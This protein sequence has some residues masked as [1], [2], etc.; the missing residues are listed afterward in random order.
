MADTNREI[1]PGKIR[2]DFPI[3]R[4]RIQGRP[5]AY[6]DNAATAQRPRQV[7]SAV[8]EFYEQRNANVHR[9][10]HTLS[11]EASL[12]YEEAHHKAA[13]FIGAAGPEEIVF[14]HN[15]T[16]A[17]N[18]VAYAFGLWGLRQGDEVLLT[19]AEHHSNLV[20]WQALRRLKGV[21]LKF[22]DVD[23][24]GRLKLEELPQLLSGR[25]KLVGIVHASNILGT[26]NPVAEISREAH[27]VGAR[28]LVD[29]AQS[30][31]HLPLDVAE[32]D[33]DFLAASGHKMLGPTGTGFLY[34]K[35]DL[36]EEM[37]PFLYGG[38]MIETVSLERAT[39]NKLPWKFEAGTPNIA[40]GIGLA[41]AIDYLKRLGMEEV[42]RH[43]RRLLEYAWERLSGVEGLKLYGPA[44]NEA[45][46][47]GIITFNL[48]GIHPHDVAAVLDS[49]GVAVRSGHHCAQPLMA[50]L[51]MDFAVRASFYIYNTQEEVDRLASALERAR[52]AF[53]V[54]A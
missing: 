46:R 36:L 39:W 16:E 33:C 22:L 12:A 7:I 28:V 10:V 14:T 43:E 5:L 50:R 4:R 1:N 19:T 2:G 45:E 48:Q 53:P 35:R 21:K 25:T 54:Q 18:L 24:R 41:A 11:Y 6:L 15:A 23:H 42:Y 8:R 30:V 27:R 31:P 20:P 49:E 9:A 13:E 29:A 26:V 38:S 37:E 3:F 51:G 47:L 32:L 17:L 40:G 52:E 44:P 34:A